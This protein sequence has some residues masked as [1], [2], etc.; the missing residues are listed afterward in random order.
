MEKG[1]NK[2]KVGHYVSIVLVIKCEFYLA[3]LVKSLRVE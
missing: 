3:Q 2:I 1:K